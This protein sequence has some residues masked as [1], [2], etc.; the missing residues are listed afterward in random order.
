M[1]ILLLIEM[2]FLI[3]WEMLHERTSLSLVLLLV[4]V[5]FVSGF[6]LE[7]FRLYISLI[8]NIRSNLTHLHD[9]QLLVLLFIEITFF[10]YIKNTNRL[11]LKWR[12]HRQVINAKGFWK[13]PNLLMLIKQ[14]SPLL[15]RTLALLTFGELLIVFSTT[16]VNLL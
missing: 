4:Q 3:I 11:I 14:K 13:L 2:V 1:T 9:F 15:T 16:K 7:L 5:N 10:V 12:S 8:E 6:R